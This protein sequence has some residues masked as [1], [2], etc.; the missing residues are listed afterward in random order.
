MVVDASAGLGDD[1]AIVREGVPV[2]ARESST[3]ASGAEHPATRTAAI[4]ATTVTRALRI[5]RA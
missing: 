2:G 3:V 1:S 5:R 4:V